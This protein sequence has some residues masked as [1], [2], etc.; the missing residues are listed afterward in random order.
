MSK[1]RDKSRCS[2]CGAA[3]MPLNREKTEFGVCTFIECK[4]PTYDLDRERREQPAPGEPSYTNRHG[5][6]CSKACYEGRHEE[7]TEDYSTCNCTYRG[8][9]KTLHAYMSVPAQPEGGEKPPSIKHSPTCSYWNLSDVC[10]CSSQVNKPYDRDE[11]KRLEREIELEGNNRFI[12]MRKPSSPPAPAGGAREFARKRALNIIGLLQVPE[13]SIV[14]SE[15]FNVAVEVLTSELEAIAALGG[16]CEKH[17]PNASQTYDACW[18]CSREEESQTL[19]QL[20][21]ER[22]DWKRDATYHKALSEK[23]VE[24]H[25]SEREARERAEGALRERD[26]Q[27]AKAVTAWEKVEIWPDGSTRFLKEFQLALAAL[28]SNESNT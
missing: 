18:R 3:R 8:G 13:G 12:G 19:A 7:C 15:K 1:E 14:N 6:P 5:K 20:R 2:L 26:E 4:N 23:A 25:K 9:H 21:Q 22:D 17:K 11:V 24:A 28:K 10:N 27:I 16:F